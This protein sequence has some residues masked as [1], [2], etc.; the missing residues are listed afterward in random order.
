MKKKNVSA[1]RIVPAFG[2]YFFQYTAEKRSVSLG[3]NLL[4]VLAQPTG[5]PSGCPQKPPGILLCQ[6]RAGGI[7]SKTQMLLPQTRKLV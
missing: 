1:E 5:Q 6:N 4:P 7:T 3:R 2:K